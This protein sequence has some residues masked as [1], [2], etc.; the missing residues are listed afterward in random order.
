MKN[1]I[2]QQVLLSVMATQAEARNINEGIK[3]KYGEFQA[4]F[5]A[6]NAWFGRFKER[7]V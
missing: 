3:K 1:E 7:L 5:V 2:Q 6:S 4:K